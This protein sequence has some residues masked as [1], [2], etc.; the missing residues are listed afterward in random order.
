[1]MDE[2]LQK[3]KGYLAME[4][5]LPF[6]E[7]RQYYT[8]LIQA[9]TTGFETMDNKNRVQGRYICQIVAS[10]ARARVGKSRELTKKFRKMAEKCDFWA[11]AI[12]YRLNKEGLSKAEIENMNAAVE[13]FMETGAKPA[14][15]VDKPV[16]TLDKPVETSE[17]L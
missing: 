9:L 5:E 4:E 10:N 7:F 16:E 14:E 15:A 12:E 11:E 13:K 1:M 2:L 3:L 6:A 17:K 8:E